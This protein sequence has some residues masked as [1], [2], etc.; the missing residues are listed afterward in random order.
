MFT[1]TIGF[2]MA[3]V[4]GPVVFA[5][6]MQDRV[7]Y[8]KN[9]TT[10]Q[11]L[12]E[13]SNGI[14]TI[15]EIR[16]VAPSTEQMSLA[17]HGTAEQ[18]A[19]AEWLVKEL[20]QPVGAS[21]SDAIREYKGAPGDDGRGHA[22]QDDVVRVLYIPNAASVQD[23][24]EVANAIRTTTEIRRVFT[25]NSGRAM[26]VKGTP[27]Q[28]AWAEWMVHELDQSTAN[29]Q[30][31]ANRSGAHEYTIGNTD[32][33]RVFYVANAKTVQ[34]FQEMINAVRTTVEIRRV[35]TYNAARAVAARG[36][37]GEIAMVEWLLAELDK[38]AAASQAAAEYRVPDAADD[39]VRVYRLTNTPTV[40][41]FQAEANQI[42]TVAEI[43]RAFT[44]N[45]QRALTLRGTTG[46]LAIAENLM[47][48][49]DVH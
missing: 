3:M 23:F 41:A 22:T 39:V 43:R 40:Q 1:R 38:P 17:V 49:M 20:D 9:I 14:R 31:D 19:V 8:F 26:V 36:T 6:A 15:I 47:R 18:I 45:S 32:V 48:Q 10:A 16:D 35:F 46:Q 27:D 42:R 29:A 2:A 33:M 34:D 7:F 21:A 44:Y 37:P 25:Y 30:A 12:Q 11:E 24:Q 13:V 5:Q 28:I 4:V